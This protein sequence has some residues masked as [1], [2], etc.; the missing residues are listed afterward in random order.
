M[1]LDFFLI[2]KNQGIPVSIKEYLTLL[3]ALKKNV[4]AQKVD[5]FYHL[6]KSIIIIP[7]GRDHTPIR[8]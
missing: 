7:A 4:I 6:S 8:S 2:L 3:E 1:F 5:E